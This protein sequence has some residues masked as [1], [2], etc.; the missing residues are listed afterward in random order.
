MVKFQKSQ[1]IFKT[2]NEIKKKFFFPVGK[3]YIPRILQPRPAYF[4]EIILQLY[5]LSITYPSIRRKYFNLE[6]LLTDGQMVETLTPTYGFRC[7][8]G[9]RKKQKMFLIGSMRKRETR[10][11]FQNASHTFSTNKNQL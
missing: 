5:F 10:L 1:K 11:K 9:Y 2:G 3:S 7:V 8:L 4:P 6:H